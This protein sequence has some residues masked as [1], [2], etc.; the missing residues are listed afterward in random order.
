MARRRSAK[1][2]HDLSGMRAALYCRVSHIQRSG[3]KA[4]DEKSVDDQEREGRAWATR[5]GVDLV[6]V[7]RD[8]GLSASPFAQKGRGR[9]ARPD[10]DQMLTLVETGEV[11]VVWVWAIDR[12]Q[13]DLRVFTE[14]RD[15]F[16]DHQV[17]LS[18]NGKLHHP[19][20]YDDWMLLGITSQ[21]AE[22]YS[23]DLSKNVRRGQKSAAEAGLPHGFAAFGYRRR[24]AQERPADL[25]E[26]QIWLDKH[27]KLYVW[28]EPDL[29]DGDG[30][31]ENTPAAVVREIYRRIAAG[32]ATTRIARDLNDRGVD[33]PRNGTPTP[34][35]RWHNT[36]VR[37]IALNPVYIGKRVYQHDW[38]RPGE[39]HKSAMGPALWPPLIDEETYW[40]VHRI[41]TDPTRKKHRPAAAK[42]LLS[43]LITCATCGGDVVAGWVSRK[44]RHYNV[45]S[46]SH[47]RC[48]SI[49]RE[50]LD[51]YIEE[52]M[53]G[54]LSNPDVFE[55]L[56]RVD[57]SAVAAQARTDA[58]QARAEL[59]QWRQAAEAGRITLTGYESAEK[60]LLTRIAEAEKR[61]QQATTPAELIGRIGP[62]AEA[63]WRQA[64]NE[65]KRQ[66]IRR[67]ADI[68]LKPAGMSGPM[69]RWYG[70]SAGERVDIR[71]LIGPPIT[72][73]PLTDTSAP[74]R[75]L[76]VSEQQALTE[77]N[78]NGSLLQTELR[79]RLGMGQGSTD[80][81][82][83]RMRERGWITSELAP[84]QGARGRRTST[85]TITEAG[86]EALNG[87]VAI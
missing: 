42:S 67:V 43:C 16:Q 48:A 31:V 22:R 45:Y 6:A 30:P 18:V 4:V 38:R 80:A 8:S 36:R 46:C 86:R 68:T 21:I 57:D 34:K 14:V 51:E 71:P 29:W 12:S 47:R 69:A 70:P 27:T 20:D 9:E 73:Q 81:V 60:G 28:Q 3:Q 2:F 54:W 85:L 10:F 5:A 40:T 87:T 83:R 64:T 15:L 7:F 63:A 76:L 55:A 33:L 13:R 74:K 26:D 82:F 59:A 35:S 78:R 77:L 61:A 44:G 56:T 41:L 52:V 50:A 49:A 62:E 17:A 32:D 1:D 19:D 39:A 84:R 58:A 23:Y 24:R 25:P 72:D 53:V 75:R 11:D 37:R 65:V 79:D 66:I